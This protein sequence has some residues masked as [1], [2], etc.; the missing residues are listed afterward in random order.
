METGAELNVDYQTQRS[1]QATMWQ[2]RNPHIPK[3]EKEC[4][5][6]P[7]LLAEKRCNQLQ[8]EATA[9]A[10]TGAYVNALRRS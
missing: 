6:R 1:S 2:F 5:S 8:P 10:K 7:E 4:K 9:D 3:R